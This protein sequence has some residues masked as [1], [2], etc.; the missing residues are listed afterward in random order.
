MNRNDRWLGTALRVTPFLV[1]LWMVRSLLVAVALGALFALLLFPLKRRLA[2]RGPRS[3]RAAPLVL[4][5][6]ALVLVVIPFVLVAARV[7]VAAQAFLSGGVQDVVGRVQTFLDKHFAGIIEKLGVPIESV[8]SGALDVAQQV[9]TSIATFASGVAVS[10]PAQ[11]VDIFLFVLALYFFLRDG[12][13][14]LRWMMRLAPFPAE[15]VEELFESVRR[16][17]H[18]AIMGQLATSLVQG[19]L[20]LIALHVFEVPGALIL[21]V[22]ATLLSVLPLVGTMPV[23]VGAAIYLLA[24]GRPGAALGMG[25]AA[26]VIGLSDNV[27]R[28]WVQ[29]ADTRMHPL[30][31]LLAIFGGLE[32]M[33]A[34]GVFLGPVIAAMAVWTIGL[35]SDRHAAP[36]PS[37]RELAPP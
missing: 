20:S 32:L 34:A 6:G 16:T 18:G 15:D 28:P 5:I 13:G 12:P 8:R 7:V 35:Y 27:V 24:A 2:K 29:S 10:L 30:M 36:P 31:T 37:N 3:A 9:T 1:F 4:T 25:V 26:V 23:T 14:L 19:G 17:V 11:V 21:G 33:G 22:L